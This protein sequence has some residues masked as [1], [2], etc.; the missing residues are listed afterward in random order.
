[1]ANKPGRKNI[2]IERNVIE[3]YLMTIKDFV[4]R[5]SRMVKIVS[6]SILAA[7]A[8][9]A[10]GNLIYRQNS[11]SDRAKFDSVIDSYRSD[12]AN[13]ENI[14]KCKADLRNLIKETSFGY[15]HDMS[16][17]TL[18]SIVFEEKKYQEAYDLYAAFIKKS[19]S[20]KLFI[21]IAVEKAAIC[22]EEQGKYDEALNL[23]LKYQDDANFEVFRDKLLYNIGRL[24]SI[25]G[26]RVKARE[27]FNRISSEYPQSSYAERAKERM[28]YLS[29]QK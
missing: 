26:D 18:A 23:L 13:S 5:N 17:Y 24:Y 7:V 12:P 15:V 1:M 29:V 22:L 11:I 2:E 6:I 27:Y 3:K 9:L 16:Y 28:L 8:V 10:A 4:K 19:S 25:K 20:D 21:P 14:E